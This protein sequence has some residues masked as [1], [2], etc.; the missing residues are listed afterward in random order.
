MPNHVHLLIRPLEAPISRVMQSLLI[1]HTQRYHRCHHS[2][3]HVWQGRFKSLDIQDDEHLL[4]FLRYIEANPLRARMVE[5]AGDYRWSSFSAHGI[6]RPDPVLDFLTVY[7]S[8]AKTPATR[9]RRWSAFVH[10]TPSDDELAA[11]HRS[12][13]TGLPYGHPDWVTQLGRHLD[14]DQ[15]I[16]PRGRPRKTLP[17]ADL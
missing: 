4:T 3:G 15:I 17:T 13:Q 10:K 11:L 7:D 5:S 6:G 12:T 14:L 1:S 2:G 8:L 16:R 9:Q